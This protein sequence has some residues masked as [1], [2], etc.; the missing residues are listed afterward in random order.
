ML[1]LGRKYLGA[2]VISSLQFGSMNERPISNWQ[3]CFFQRSRLIGT[4]YFKDYASIYIW[5]VR[6]SSA[7]NKPI[8]GPNNFSKKKYLIR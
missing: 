3:D 8:S 7:Q 1:S 2:R 6:T 5:T 4:V